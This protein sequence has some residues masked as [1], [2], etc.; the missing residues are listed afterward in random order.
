MPTNI[1]LATAMEIT[2]LPFAITQNLSGVPEVLDG[3]GTPT[4]SL[5]YKLPAAL[6]TA[7]LLGALGVQQSSLPRLPNT[8]TFVFISSGAAY[9][10]AK[11]TT[12]GDGVVQVPP[13]DP[14]V[15]LYIQVVTEDWDPLPDYDMDVSVYAAA[16]L[17]DVP[18][19]ALFINNDE[20]GFPAAILDPVTG[21]ILGFVPDI[22]A[23]ETGD[24]LPSGIMALHDTDAGNVKI[25]NPD[26]SLR[27]TVALDGNIGS[28]NQVDTFYILDSSLIL[29]SFDAD[30]NIGGTTWG[31]MPVGTL[32][33]AVSRDETIAYLA[34]ARTAAAGGG[35]V[36]RWDLVNN[37][38]LSNLAAIVAGYIL[39]ATNVSPGGI[40][41]LADESVLVSYWRS[42]QADSFIR[43]YSAAGA[44]LHTYPYA[45]SPFVGLDRIAHDI[46]DDSLTFW[47]W[48]KGSGAVAP[49]SAFGLGRFQKLRI[50]D[51]VALVT[52]DSYEAQSGY[53]M[54]ANA[55]IT[56]QPLGHPFSCP[57]VLL[58]EAITPEPPEPPGPPLPDGCPPSSM[59]PRSIQG[60]DGCPGSL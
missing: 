15:D 28:G 45:T 36:K 16:D 58:R 35:A 6:Q 5:W 49:G 1:T 10:D 21:A 4:Y 59:E 32:M 27:A 31:P 43:H 3:F 24:I 52:L 50:S 42:N 19:G 39:Q 8:R 41:V 56:S 60:L 20:P 46:V 2:A 37:V 18:V 47:A 7:D 44:V 9:L 57:F 54:R 22:V 53:Q 26:F 48:A 25:Y 51:G 17:G 23:G 30:G 11:S 40:L 33:T 13:A 12:L 55:T 29:H 34:D 14:A 38:A